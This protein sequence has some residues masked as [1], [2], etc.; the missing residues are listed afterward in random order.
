MGGS[1]RP[2]WFAA[3]ALA[4]LERSRTGPDSSIPCKEL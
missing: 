3:E 4:T 2:L 1:A